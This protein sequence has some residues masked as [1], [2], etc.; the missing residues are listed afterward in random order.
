M[1]REGIGSGQQKKK[2]RSGFK[3][4]SDVRGARL[5]V[6]KNVKAHNLLLR[7]VKNRHKHCVAMARTR[8]RAA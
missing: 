8:S 4:S 2:R 6:S 1:L 3:S 7:P 5:R